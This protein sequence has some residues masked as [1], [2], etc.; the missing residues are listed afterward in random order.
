MPQSGNGDQRATFRSRSLLRKRFHPRNNLRPIVQ[1]FPCFRDVF[2]APCS[3]SSIFSQKQ[4]EFS[5][6][7]YSPKF[8]LGE[9]FWDLQ[10]KQN[11]RGSSPRILHRH[12]PRTARG[13]RE[14]GRHSDPCILPGRCSTSWAS[15]CQPSPAATHHLTACPRILLDH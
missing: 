11:Y 4:P 12:S 2:S 15:L 14:L 9:K 13:S 1:A 3:Y 7:R 5:T 6:L 10:N 8:T